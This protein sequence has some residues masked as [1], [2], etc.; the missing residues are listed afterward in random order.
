MQMNY[1]RYR[2][3]IKKF[4]QTFGKFSGDVL[5]N[6]IKNI[7]SMYPRE[8]TRYQIIDGEFTYLLVTKN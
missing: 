8:G 4:T 3:A 5:K 7:D 6:Y 1:V 2:M